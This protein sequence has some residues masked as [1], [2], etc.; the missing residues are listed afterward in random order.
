MG[1]FRAP[2]RAMKS[3]AQILAK[4]YTGK[5]DAEADEHLGF[6]VDGATRLEA[7]INDLLAYS[8]IDTQGKDLEP[9][10]CSVVF[11]QVKP[12]LLIDVHHSEA[13]ATSAILPTAMA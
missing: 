11:D 3:F 12:D 6:I 7:L 13:E 2:V 4:D 10:D 8:R 5:L 9:V 1:M